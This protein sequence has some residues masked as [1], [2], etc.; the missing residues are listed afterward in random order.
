M[1]LVV[2]TGTATE[3][4]KTWVGAATLHALRDLGLTVAAR[5]CAQ[6]YDPD[7]PADLATDADIL[8][9]A[10]REAPDVVCLP[11]RVYEVPMAPPMAASV[12]GR[13][14]FTIDDLAAELA[15][16]DLRVAVR[17]LET[18]G[19]VRSPLASDGCDTV[20]L[21]RLV[22]PDVV[23]LV[24]D[25]GLGAINAVRLCTSALAGW[26]VIVVLNRGVGEVTERNRAWLAEIDGFDVVT[27]I[28]TLAHRL[29][30]L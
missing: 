17:W 24:A 1:T 20:D 21:C 23:V 2:C 25:A 27:D 16:P 18:A 28:A 26:P 30:P 8:A 7:D 4:G 6:S 22:Q 9:A 14:P 10:S 19:G 11:H 12:L 3:V 13:P 5:K 29:S 15:W